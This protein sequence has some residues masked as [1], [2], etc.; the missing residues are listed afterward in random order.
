MYEKFSGSAVRL[1]H[2]TAPFAL[3]CGAT[4][5]G[6]TIA[7]HTYGTLS[8]E[9]DNV[10]WVCHALTA[11]SD[12]ADWWPG[13]VVQAGVLDAQR[14]FVVCA[15]MIGSCY[16]STSAMSE[17][18][19]P[20]IT[21]RDMV[22]AHQLLA[23]YL[24]LSRIDMLIGGSTGGSQAM[25]WAYLEPERFGRLILLATLPKTTAWI[26]ASSTAQRM[27]IEASGYSD[28]GLA[29]ARATAMLQYRGSQ[30]YNMTQSDDQ[31]KLYG[32]KVDSY[33]RYQGKKL[34]DRFDV[35]CYL[36]LLDALD[37]HDIGRGRGGV[38]KALGRITTPTTVVAISTD[39]MFPPDDIRA[40]AN[41]MPDALFHEIDSPFGHD[42]FLV[43]TAKISSIILD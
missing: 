8:A 28:Q 12:V 38:D 19:F 40:M 25:E 20:L 2:S 22:R 27:A 16:G 14:Y 6:V 42:G 34:S 1:F 3:E 21:F 37:S 9:R 18:D 41:A 30:A 7:Y 17:V 32:Y 23:D 33:Q 36:R 5:D 26:Q 13:T 4:L 39:I 11:S 35:K 43:E 24:G 29:A 15:N 10:R 31:P